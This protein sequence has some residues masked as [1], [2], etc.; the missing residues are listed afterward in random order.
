[1]SESL[2]W[3]WL[4]V[5]LGAASPYL[6]ALL[7]KYASPKEIFDATAS[8]LLSLEKIPESVKARLIDKDLD[9]SKR[10]IEKCKAL[11]IGI[12]TYSDP[13]YPRILKYIDKPPAVLYF[14]GR[15]I[16]FDKRF[17]VSI[18]GTRKMSDYGRDVAYKFSYELASAGAVIVSGM[19]LGCDGMGAAGALDAQ[20]QTVAV[21]GGGVDV[22]YPKVHKKLYDAILKDGLIISEYPPGSEADASHFPQRNR[23][24][25]GLSRCT[26]V[27]ESPEHGGSLITARYAAAQ[28]R[29]L[30]AVPGSVDSVNSVGTNNLI[31]NGAAMATSAHDVLDAFEQAAFTDLD[32]SAIGDMNFDSKKAANRYGVAV[33][34]DDKKNVKIGKQ[35]HKDDTEDFEQASSLGMEKE[36]REPEREFVSMS[37]AEKNVYDCIPEEGEV[38]M[39]LIISASGQTVSDVT[40]HLL[41]LELKKAIVSLPGA[42]YRRS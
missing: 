34:K 17:C 16:D 2:Y 12:M 24:I 11:G 31:K 14:K 25:S 42:R 29:P 1:M 7:S 21:L 28:G 26:L 32:S 39:E 13:R 33:K 8:E 27:I 10:I 4:S 22:V 36:Q 19:A 18:V 6:N 40:M 30:F 3:T 35:R 37:P 38:G 15:P 5:K 23:I 20:A 9:R 41:S